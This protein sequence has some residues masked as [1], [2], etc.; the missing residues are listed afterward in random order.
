MGRTL[1]VFACF[2]MSAQAQTQ[3][4]I[5]KLL[6]EVQI[7]NLLTTISS[8]SAIESRSVRSAGNGFAQKWITEEFVRIGYQPV[9]QCFASQ[10]WGEVCNILAIKLA[11]QPTE[12]MIVLTAHLDSVGEPYA[13]ADDNASGISGLLEIARVLRSKRSHRNIVFLANNAE[14][15]GTKGSQYFV[16]KLKSENR[17]RFV[18]SVFVMDMIGYNKANKV[19]IET[20]E[21]F[22]ADAVSFAKLIAEHIDLKTNIVVPG[23][24][25]DHIP[26]LKAGIRAFLT[27]NDSDTN[28]PCYHRACDTP[29]TIDAEYLRKMVQVNLLGVTQAASLF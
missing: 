24:G 26:F 25:S 12:E 16:S 8:L 29:N 22:R 7:Q 28:T 11:D 10:S 6:E 27:I 19:D 5:P 1:L 15:V 14:E 9:Q 13:G 17:L 23:W 4:S 20:Y 21:P 3:E 18:H 2:L